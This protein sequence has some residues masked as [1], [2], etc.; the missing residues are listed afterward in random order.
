MW[1][2]VNR[3]ALWQIVL[4]KW[5]FFYTSGGD[6]VIELNVRSVDTFRMLCQLQRSFFRREAIDQKATPLSPIHFLCLQLWLLILGND[7]KIRIA[8]RSGG[9]GAP[10]KEKCYL[11]GCVALRSGILSMSRRYFTAF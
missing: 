8:N 3:T 2:H 4:F 6:Q 1:P 9:N 7:Q 11:T 5:A 10:L